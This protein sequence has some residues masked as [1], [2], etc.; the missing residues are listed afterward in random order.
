MSTTEHI[1]PPAAPPAPPAPRRAWSPGL[2]VRAVQVRLRFIVVLAVAFLAVIATGAAAAPLNPALGGGELT[3]ELDDLRVS[4]L[5]HWRYHQGRPL[6]C[7][8]AQRRAVLLPV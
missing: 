8:I 7:R 3:L 4:R 6:I 5:L 1:T 2:I